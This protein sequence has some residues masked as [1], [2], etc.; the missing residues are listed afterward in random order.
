MCVCIYVYMHYCVCACLC[1]REAC[2]HSYPSC[3]P[4]ACC[5]SK[6]AWRS[7]HECGCAD[8]GLLAHLH[9]HDSAHTSAG[10][11]CLCVHACVCVS[12][13]GMVICVC[14]TVQGVCTHVCI[15]CTYVRVGNTCHDYQVQETKRAVPQ[16]YGHVCN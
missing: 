12:M 2:L 6:A 11:C 7:G 5:Q 13:C 1:V 15:V 14:G 8:H 3:L 9:S 16:Q 10:Q 4:P